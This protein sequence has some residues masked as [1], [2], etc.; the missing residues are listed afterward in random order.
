MPL[1]RRD[2]Q[3]YLMKI[4]IL[5][6][7]LNC[8]L[9]QQDSSEITRAEISPLK[10]NHVMIQVKTLQ[11]VRLSAFIKNLTCCGALFPLEMIQRCQFNC[12]VR[13]H[14]SK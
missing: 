12:S 2:S 6:Y 4:F 9:Y 7:A 8:S 13:K 1:E 10:G 14:Y 3:F 11:F 5:Q